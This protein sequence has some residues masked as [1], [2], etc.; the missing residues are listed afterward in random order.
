MMIPPPSPV[1]EPIK[2]ASNAPPNTTPVNSRMFISSLN[3]S[4]RPGGRIVIAFTLWLR[5]DA[6]SSSDRPRD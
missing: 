5:K 3:E 6:P 2:P 1:S 4:G